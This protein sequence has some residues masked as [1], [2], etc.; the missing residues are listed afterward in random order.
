MVFFLREKCLLLQVPKHG[1]EKQAGSGFNHS[2]W[3]SCLLFVFVST[4]G[5][6]KPSER[7]GKLPFSGALLRAGTGADGA[8]AA[9]DE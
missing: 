8:G 1:A 3:V 6:H 5:A 7:A 9:T 2:E 4:A